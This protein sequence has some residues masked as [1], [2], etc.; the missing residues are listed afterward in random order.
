ME[1]GGVGGRGEA[2]TGGGKG[3]APDI[4]VG[5]GVVEKGGGAPENEA[6]GDGGHDAGLR[7]NSSR[8]GTGEGR[9][10]RE[11]TVPRRLGSEGGEFRED[12][13][14]ILSNKDCFFCYYYGAGILKK[15]TILVE[16]K[17]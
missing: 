14:C 16:K 12:E 9:G 5:E 1:G 7:R 6:R 11:V 8:C 3:A 10:E 4:E 13:F 15:I 2:A 17:I